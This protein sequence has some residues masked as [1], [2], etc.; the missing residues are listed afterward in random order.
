M[1][2][3]ISQRVAWQ[4]IAGEVVVVDLVAGRALGLNATGTLLWP[5]LTSTSDDELVHELMRHFDV[6]EATAEADVTEFLADLERRGLI[7][8]D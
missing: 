1:T 2:W 5:L 8:R 3:R 4:R 7:V 6:D